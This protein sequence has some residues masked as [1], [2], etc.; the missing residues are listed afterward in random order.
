[1]NHAKALQGADFT[2]EKGT[3]HGL[4]G[5]NAA[6]K[7]TLMKI[8]CGVHQPDSGGILINGQQVIFH[9]PV[10]SLK[11]GIGMVYQHF[12]LVEE[13]SVLENILLSVSEK[14]YKRIRKRTVLK[15]INALLNYYG[16]K[17]DPHDK[18]HTLSVGEKQ[19]VEIIRILFLN[20]DVLIMDEPTAVLSEFEKEKL[21]SVL[22]QLKEQGKAIVFISHNLNE[23]I[24]LCDDITVFRK[25]R[26][27][28]FQEKDYYDK[29]MILK[30]MLGGDYQHFF[31][32]EFTGIK[33]QVL[34]VN[35]LNLVSSEGQLLS[36]INFELCSGHITGI[37]GFAG[38]G[39]LQL[40][41]T[42]FSANINYNGTVF[43]HDKDIRRC[44]VF[45]KREAGIAYIPEDR[46]YHGSALTIELMYNLTANRLE[47][48]PFSKWK[49]IDDGYVEQMAK[50]LVN[51]YDIDTLSVKT[52]VGLLSGGNI[53][54]AVIARETHTTPD[55]LLIHEPTRGL[56]SAAISFTYRILNDLKHTETAI[57]MASS[58]V[59]ELMEVCDEIYVMFEGRF[60]H[61][62]KKG[63]YDKQIINEHLAGFFE[64][65]D[66]RFVRKGSKYEA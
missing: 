19:L 7:S 63:A 1:M 59:E 40:F 24:Q 61:H 65:H 9:S 50:E 58:N 2:I 28:F 46:L 25:G 31:G 41:E 56:D 29:E 18:V 15:K 21:F 36:D 39:Q 64:K 49:M 66:E 11:A 22:R 62:A 27:S 14:G 6:G 48:P 3:I 45:E 33:Q 37:A 38:N 53:Q 26:N 42:I 57:L 47:K 44:S 55:L 54:K 20:V 13:L 5:E 32:T 51:N 17:I 43:Y 12:R 16:F 34:R 35:D 10:D 60:V 4:L 23:V 8:L 52:P 30:E